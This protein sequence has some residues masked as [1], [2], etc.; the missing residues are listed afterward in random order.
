MEGAEAGFSAGFPVPPKDAADGREEAVETWVRVERG[1]ASARIARA[2]SAPTPAR[3][4]GRG[5]FTAH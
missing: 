1:D 5:A 3:P 2:M 4:R